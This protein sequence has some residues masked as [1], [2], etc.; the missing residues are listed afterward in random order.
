MS[1]SELRKLFEDKASVPA[2]ASSVLNNP[3]LQV[4][5]Y[6]PII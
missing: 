2:K 1:T 3:Q 6:P 5:K 4:A